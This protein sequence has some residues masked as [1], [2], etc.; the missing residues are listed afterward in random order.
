MIQD[1]EEEVR[2][3]LVRLRLRNEEQIGPLNGRRL[4]MQLVPAQ[5]FREIQ[6][7]G[8]LCVHSCHCVKN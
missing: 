8:F 4:R 1:L 5:V 2:S 7:L 6:I 3:D